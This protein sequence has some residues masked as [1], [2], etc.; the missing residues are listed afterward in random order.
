MH[1][2]NPIDQWLRLG[3]HYGCQLC[4]V[5]RD[6][7]DSRRRSRFL[8][9]TT[10]I[11]CE[12]TAASA[13]QHRARCNTSNV[14]WNSFCAADEEAFER[15]STAPLSLRDRVHRFNSVLLAA[16]K[17]HVGKS[18]EGRYT[19]PWFTPD[20]RDA[21]K[22]RNA[23]RSQTNGLNTCRPVPRPASSQ[24]KPAKR[25]GRYSWPT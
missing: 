24:K 8:S 25:N 23:E 7:V 15:F 12:V 14:D 21:I 3:R 18:K 5:N 20:H 13:S 9:I 4:L 19:K 1:V 11:R 6:R 22:K 2:D 17:L 10:T 16:A